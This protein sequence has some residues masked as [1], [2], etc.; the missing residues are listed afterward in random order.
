MSDSSRTDAAPEWA[1]GLIAAELG[2]EE[3]VLW[4]GRPVQGVRLQFPDVLRAA[5]NDNV[6]A[7]KFLIQ[8]GANV[9]ATCDFDALARGYTALHIA[10]MQ[11]HWRVA[12]FLIASGL[13]A[14]A[15]AGLG[16]TPL[17]VAI[18]N[19]SEATINVLHQHGGRRGHR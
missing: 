10:A 6:P 18:Q 1:E 5:Y 9:R 7:A 13:P 3:K 16:Q 8:R 2:P 4:S 15:E 19:K 12:Q 17:D 11:N 14:N